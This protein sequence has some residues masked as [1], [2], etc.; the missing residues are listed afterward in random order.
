MNQLSCGIWRASRKAPS[1]IWCGR[2]QRASARVV[3]SQSFGRMTRELDRRRNE[4]LLKAKQ[5]EAEGRRLQAWE[6][7]VKCVDITPKHAFQLIKA[8]RAEGVSYV[9]A[10]YEVDAQ[11]A[12]PEQAG[13]VDDILTEDSDLLVFGCQNVYYFKLDV[14]AYIFLVPISHLT[15]TSIPHYGRA[16]SFGTTSC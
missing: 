11:L 13:I 7:Y 6:M 4:S 14:T 9:V 16:R 3:L 15:R 8:L 2:S 10:P 1:L 12:Y 5:V